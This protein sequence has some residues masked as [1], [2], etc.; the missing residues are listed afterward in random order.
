MVPYRL[1]GEQIEIPASISVPREIQ[2]DNASGEQAE[3]RLWA[4]RALVE[5]NT[6]V[7]YGRE[8]QPVDEITALGQVRL[9]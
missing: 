4:A 9:I 3:G 6:Q 8:V 5:V 1:G 2:A 7:L